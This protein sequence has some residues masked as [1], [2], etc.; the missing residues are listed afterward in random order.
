M[1]QTNTR[2]SGI[3]C[4]L[5]QVFGFLPFSKASKTS[6]HELVQSSRT[7]PTLTKDIKQS[8]P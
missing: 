6:Q 4:A 5:P 8:I 2:N 3:D 1:L 7:Y